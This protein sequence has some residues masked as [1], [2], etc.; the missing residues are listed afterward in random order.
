MKKRRGSLI[1]FATLLHLSPVSAVLL[2]QGD[3][4][5]TIDPA[6][7]QISADAVVVNNPQPTQKVSEL[8]ASSAQANWRWPDRNIQITA[9]PDGPD[10]YLTI[11][12]DRSQAV[13]WFS[14]PPHFSTLQLPIGEGSRIP[15]DNVQWLTYLTTALSTVDTN[16]DL[17]LP[18][19]GLEQQGMTYSWLQ[20][21]PFSN[22]ISFTM[23]GNQLAMQSSHAFNRFNQ[24]QSFDVLL[25]VGTTPLS[26]AIRYREYLQQSHQFSSLREKMVTAP[27]GKKLIGATHIYLWG[28]TLLAQ[29]D[30]KN[31]PG[32]IDYLRSPAGAKIWQKM[33]AEDR[34]A[35]E[36]LPGR[37]P[38]DWQKLSLT[39]AIN[40][41]LVA[42]AP[43][44][45]TPDSPSFL[46][47]QQQ[48]AVKVRQLAQQLLGDYLAPPEQW[49]P[50]LSDPV[51]AALKKAGLERLWLGTDNWTVDF[52]HPQAVERAKE[53]GYLIGSYDS[54]DTGIP[55]GVNDSWL[56]AQLP[57]EITE[58]CAIVRA[59]GTKLPGFGGDGY[60]LN[61]G[62]IL[63]YSQVRM[64]EL[65]Q[66]SGLNSLFLDV[67]G[68]GMV[69]DDYQT[70]HPT[71]AAQMAADRNA[72]M[73]WFSN[74]LKLPLGSEDGNA[75]TARHIMFAHGTE[76]WGFGW[77]DK[78]MRQNK[79]SPYYLGIWWPSA[80]PATFFSP[81]KVK[82]LYRTVMFDPRYRLPL[83]QAVFHDAV[84][85]THHWTYDNL[86]FSD[87]KTTRALLSEL[88]NTPPLFNLSR[89]TLKERLPEVIK[90]DARFRVL[91]EALWD[92]AL[93]GFQWLDKEGW[94]Q[95]TTF[96]DG[97]V[98]TANFSDKTVDGLA[99]H[100]LK[101][102]L[103]DG[104]TLNFEH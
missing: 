37:A 51:I 69:S 26:G 57:H 96:S 13:N 32:L 78:D 15:L 16:F 4:K 80:Q 94:V 21:T 47:A 8:Q 76:T 44:N 101:A 6:T 43:L 81:A 25:H 29:E 75:V 60:Y 82:P 68:T 71:G 50:G 27:E 17:K 31:W 2:Q 30:V 22:Q 86:K 72:R 42:L 99:A 91:H 98:L 55:P 38:G 20:L 11:R 3:V 1:F 95:Q 54:Y 103:A 9:K 88:Y 73:A 61:P 83:Y 67:D 41:A 64:R 89:S 102:T 104:R 58:K 65:I 49:G 87:V 74:T 24:Q 90:A 77:G 100:T 34:K 18:F 59:D 35:I 46:T 7:L 23:T 93:T 92:K 52:L 84:I 5:F 56:T 40:R 39:D 70:E 45:V 66:L 85:A 62:C 53:A 10:L 97:S 48:Q 79:A 14:L 28:N 12:S 19:W 63:P 36:K 33:T